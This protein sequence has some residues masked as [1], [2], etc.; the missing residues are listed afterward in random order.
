M[1]SPRRR[2]QPP[3]RPGVRQRRGGSRAASGVERLE[4]RR[5]MSVSLTS[6][7]STGFASGNDVSEDPDISSNGRYVVFTSRATDL[8]PEDTNAV[9]D[10]YLRDTQSGVTQLV[11]AA[12][13]G[14]G[15]GNGSSIDPSVSDDGRYV[16]FSSIASNLVANDVNG[17]SDVFVRDMFTGTTA[18]VSVANA[19]T[20]VTSANG[21]SLQPS[22]SDSGRIVAFA[23][24]A[25][26]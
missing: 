21:N 4:D 6:I 19:V 14:G 1:V 25:T 15:A 2:P 12:A 13:T 20:P 17:L 3:L 26:N 8:V 11:S 24:D 5:L 23:S 18:L 22:I 7:D 9:F 16:A 10:I